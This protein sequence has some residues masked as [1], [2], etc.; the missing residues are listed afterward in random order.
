VHVCEQGRGREPVGSP[1]CRMPHCYSPLQGREKDIVIFS[2]VR[3]AG[4]VHRSIG[5]VADERRINVG[6]TRARCSLIV[7][8]HAESL[9]TDAR[10]AP[11]RKR[12]RKGD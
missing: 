9:I 7:V 11:Q 5:F 4:A 10:C 6:L 8:G 12:R 1:L 2:A 3:T